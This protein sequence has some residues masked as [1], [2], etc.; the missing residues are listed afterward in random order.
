MAGAAHPDILEQLDT[1]N[2]P[3]AA[4]LAAHAL[5][6]G[7]VVAYNFIGAVARERWGDP[8]ALGGGSVAITSVSQ[9][10]VVTPGGLQN[11]VA[12]DTESRVPAPPRDKA[13]RKRAPAEDPD[14]ISLKT[15]RLKKKQSDIAAS[16][17]RY[18]ASKE[19]KP[20]QL[21]SATGQAM[22]SPMYGLTTGSGGV[23]L[24]PGGVFGT[25]YGWYERLLRERVA[26]AWRTDD[27]D[28]RMQTAPPVIVVFDIFRDGSVR[29]VRLLQRSGIL[30]LDNSAQRAVLQASPLPQLPSDFSR[31]SASV[32]FWFQ[33]KR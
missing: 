28:P 10:P 2:R 29:N 7:S 1:L 16:S 19:E 26:R 31:D 33:L 23:G 32:E 9:I 21:Y 18:R 11:P 15:Q 27:V 4:S 22:S 30:A 5:L 6:A 14:A 13:A 8:T 20:N 25:R 24:G 17:Q 12:N 3:L